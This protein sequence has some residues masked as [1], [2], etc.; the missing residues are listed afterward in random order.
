MRIRLFSETPS[1][2]EES[3]FKVRET[4]TGLEVSL[5]DRTGRHLQYIFNIDSQG[6]T[7][8]GLNTKT[9]RYPFTVDDSKQIA[10]D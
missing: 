4:G 2:D 9:Q 3:F 1:V 5:V 8:F 10:I 6:I 7:R